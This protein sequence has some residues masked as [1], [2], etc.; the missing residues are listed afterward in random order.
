MTSF[1]ARYRGSCLGAGVCVSATVGSHLGDDR[2]GDAGT[3]VLVSKDTKDPEGRS[4]IS[5]SEISRSKV[6]TEAASSNGNRS[7]QCTQRAGGIP[8]VASGI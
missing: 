5:R 4:D 8:D 1:D 7:N 2:T 3:G 6:R